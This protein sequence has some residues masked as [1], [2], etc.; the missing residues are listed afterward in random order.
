MMWLLTLAWLAS[1][2]TAPHGRIA[3]CCAAY[4]AAS[5]VRHCVDEDGHTFEA[6]ETP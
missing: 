1:Q 2:T 6:K 5:G 3:I 4:H